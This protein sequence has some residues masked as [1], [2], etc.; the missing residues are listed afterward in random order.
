MKLKD[1][2]RG[3]GYT[4]NLP[5]VN[6]LREKGASLTELASKNTKNM[7][8]ANSRE[9]EAGRGTKAKKRHADNH[10]NKVLIMD[11]ERLSS[12]QLLSQRRDDGG[13]ANYSKAQG[14]SLVL[15]FQNRCNGPFPLCLLDCEKT[16]KTVS[17]LLYSSGSRSSRLSAG[18]WSLCF[19]FEWVYCG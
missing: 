16:F 13:R 19:S 8:K 2:S 9:T 10:E 17:F 14:L 12:D 6:G 7:R 1:E 4:R 3:R 11:L 18:L 5:A 15:H